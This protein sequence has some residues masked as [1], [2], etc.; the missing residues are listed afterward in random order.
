MALAAATLA[1]QPAEASS[2]LCGRLEAQLASLGRAAAT[3]QALRYDKAI[4]KQEIELGKARTQA[5]NAGCDGLFG[6][7]RGQCGSLRATLA[8]MEGNLASLRQQRSE[9]G[10]GDRS[11]E[12]KRIMASLASNGCN[13]EASAKDLPGVREKQ[14]VLFDRLFGGKAGQRLEDTPEASGLRASAGSYRTLCVRTCDGYFFPISYSSAPG[15]FD[16]D[17]KACRAACP[18]TEVELFY[19]SVPE[20]EAAQA[21]S[22][23]TGLSYSELENAFLYRQTDYSRPSACG[24]NPPKGFSIVAGSNYEQDEVSGPL[25]GAEEQIAQSVDPDE[26][27]PDLFADD[28][29]PPSAEPLTASV[30]REDK[31]VERRVRVVGP[32]FLPDPEEAI[33]LRSPGRKRDP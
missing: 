13:R 11:R 16:R 4:R 30:E 15:G 6:A 27:V 28:E 19:H 32:V 21:V 20:E 33:D 26:Q 18:G 17:E 3:G 12:R 22:A 10:G 8:R 7:W 1:P 29:Q 31:P 23:S 9:M 24:C 14:P 25:P 5:S 2:Q